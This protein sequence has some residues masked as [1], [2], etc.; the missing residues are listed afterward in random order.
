M[1]FAADT[2][3]EI[4]LYKLSDNEFINHVAAQMSINIVNMAF[5][6]VCII[7]SATLR[8]ANNRDSNQQQSNEPNT[9]PYNY[10]DRR[11]SNSA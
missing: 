4:G 7:F 10:S 11:T 8:Q 1:I 9:I 5:S 3:N 2:F 6:I